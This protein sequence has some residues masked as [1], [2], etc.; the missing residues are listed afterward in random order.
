MLST[1]TMDSALSSNSFVLRGVDFDGRSVVG[2]NA[3]TERNRVRLRPGFKRAFL[4]KKEKPSG[5]R[6]RF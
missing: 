2:R 6:K 5:K 3:F 1:E 4:F